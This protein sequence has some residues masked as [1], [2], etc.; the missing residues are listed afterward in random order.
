[1]PFFSDVP[2]YAWKRTLVFWLPLVLLLWIGLIAL[3]VVVHRQWAD[4]EQLP[5]PIATFASALLPSGGGARGAVFRNKLFWIG[6][7]A[8]F[9]IHMNNFGCRW[10]PSMI[11]FPIRFDLS[12]LNE[13]FPHLHPLRFTIFFI[14]S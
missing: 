6:L 3:S 5:Y 11:D 4:H 10:F 12:A 2:W 9:V 1:M 8:V 7:T 14:L 13:K